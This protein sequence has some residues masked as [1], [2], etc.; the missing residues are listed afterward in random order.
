ML[1]NS[2]NQHLLEAR[3]GLIPIQPW[4]CGPSRQ[5]VPPLPY[6]TFSGYA[7][8]G[9]YDPLV[10]SASTVRFRKRCGITVCTFIRLAV[11]LQRSV[12]YRNQ[13]QRNAERCRQMQVFPV[14]F[15]SN[16][17]LKQSC[18]RDAERSRQTQMRDFSF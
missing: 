18:R 3:G 1:L 7:W 6:R 12:Q 9:W 4:L 13:V 2:T 11:V 16:N 10:L 17:A 14:G 8:C 15:F 5:V